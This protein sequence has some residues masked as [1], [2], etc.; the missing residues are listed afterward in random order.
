MLLSF[1]PPKESNQRTEALEGRAREHSEQKE[2]GK[3][4]R[5]CFSP[6]AQCHFPLQK[7]ESGSRLFRVSPRAF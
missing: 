7:T 4:Y 3:D 5:L 2:A 6:I 1:V